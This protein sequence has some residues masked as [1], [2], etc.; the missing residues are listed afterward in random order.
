MEPISLQ[1][2]FSALMSVSS[3]SSSPR[4][5]RRTP[6]P[7]NFFDLDSEI[8]NKNSE[9][10][11]FS[12][13]IGEWLYFY[14]IEES[15]ITVYTGMLT[16]ENP[17]KCKCLI[18]YYRIKDVGMR[19]VTNYNICYKQY[20]L[21][22]RIFKK[23]VNCKGGRCIT[24]KG[25]KFH[26][27]TQNS[28]CC[29]YYSAVAAVIYR[30]YQ[31]QSRKFPG[32]KYNINFTDLTLQEINKIVD[33]FS[34]SRVNSM[35]IKLFNLSISYTSYFHLYS[36]SNPII[37]SSF[38]DITTQNCRFDYDD[39][40]IQLATIYATTNGVTTTYH[41]FCTYNKNKYIIISDSWAELK[42]RRPLWTRFVSASDFS[43]VVNMI[44]DNK[45]LSSEQLEIIK[46]F[47][48]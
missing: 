28:Y 1:S 13:L 38:T 44:Q 33:E 42:L 19:I 39:D 3:L 5:T 32:T 9:I 7:R 35:I 20:Y 46:K 47:F 22:A 41:H 15:S 48:F 18:D 31:I 34:S 4:L 14:E 43:R 27:F 11:T 10:T 30:Y 26:R 17:D 2:P 8:R 24:A 6:S 36:K 16:P 25:Q 12:K 45:T 23:L 29:G 37:P 40:K 21:F